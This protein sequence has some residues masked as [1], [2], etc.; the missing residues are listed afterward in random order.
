LKSLTVISAGN[1]AG[2]DNLTVGPE[3]AVQ[4][5]DTLTSATSEVLTVNGSSTTTI[6]ENN[7]AA[8]A[9]ITVNGGSG[10]TAVSITQTE[11]TV[12]YDGIVNIV[13][14]NGASKTEAGTITKIVLDGLSHYTNDN[15]DNVG[16]NHI[17]DNAL[18]DLTV[19]NS[20]TSQ[21]EY[22]LAAVG[23]IITNNLTTPTATTLNLSLSHD[24]IDAAGTAA[25]TLAITDLNNAYSTVHLSLGAE[26][27]SLLLHFNGLITLDTP[28]AGTGAL[29]GNPINPSGIIDDVDAAVNFDFSGLNG[30]NNIAVV[31]PSA[32]NNDVYTLGNFGSDNGFFGNGKGQFQQLQIDNG[33][34]DN[35]DIINFG[36]GAYIITDA[37]HPGASHNY[38]QTAANGSGLANLDDDAAQWAIINN[39]HGGSNSDTLLFK[40]DNPQMFSNFGQVETI[41]DG[42]SFALGLPAHTLVAFTFNGN[43]FIFDHANDSFALTPADAMVELTGIHPIAA[44]SAAHVLTF[45]M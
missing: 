39:V 9:G 40:T 11:T 41:E 44:I 34:A 21:G 12:G 7:L 15:H 29:L 24:G 10:T 13:D 35:T 1:E 45:L 17:I 43:T 30:P 32:N 3:T 18:T 38:V 20:D 6:I 25:S 33:A 23:L 27:S 28:N 4:I 22:F 26:D 16:P 37:P 42:I 14:V 31:R 8:N 2:A 5:T 36:S 19:N